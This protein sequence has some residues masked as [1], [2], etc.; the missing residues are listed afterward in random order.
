MVNKKG[1]KKDKKNEKTVV[2]MTYMV[3]L[4]TVCI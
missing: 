3:I 4:A 1:Q 2:M